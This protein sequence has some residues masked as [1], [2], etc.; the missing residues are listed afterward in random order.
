LIEKFTIV[1]E[2]LVLGKFQAETDDKLIKNKKEIRKID[3]KISTVE[4]L[5]FVLFS[6]ILVIEIFEFTIYLDLSHTSIS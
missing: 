6:L 1:V 2:A 5:P 4:V 3:D